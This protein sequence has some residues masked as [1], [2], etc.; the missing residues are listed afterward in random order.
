MSSVNF[1]SFSAGAERKN[2]TDRERAVVP[3]PVGNQREGQR[4]SRCRFSS[5]PSGIYLLLPPCV[6]EPE[7]FSYST[8]FR[9]RPQSYT[10]QLGIRKTTPLAKGMS[11]APVCEQYLLKKRRRLCVFVGR[12]VSSEPCWLTCAELSGGL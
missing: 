5:R 4:I 3:L 8:L 12:P 10:S 1:R 6:Q 11:E 9:S 2:S 7:E